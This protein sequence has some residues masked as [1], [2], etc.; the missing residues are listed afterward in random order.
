MDFDS[1][2]VSL[3]ALLNGDDIH[4]TFNDVKGHSYP[5]PFVSRLYLYTFVTFFITSVLN[6]FIFII[7]DAYHTAKQV[8]SH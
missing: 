3:F 2:M 6:V 4:A 5:L 7:E 1:T 8:L